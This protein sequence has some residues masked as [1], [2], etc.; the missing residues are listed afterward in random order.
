MPR[1]WVVVCLGMGLVGCGGAPEPAER[2]ATSPEGSGRV[3]G[4]DELGVDRWYTTPAAPAPRTLVVFWEVWCPHCVREMPKVGE[5]RDRVEGL[6]VVGLTRQSRGTSD[7][8]VAA[9][10]DEHGLDF[11]VG[12]TDGVLFEELGMRGIPA[13]VLLE[14]DRVVWEGH[15][16]RLT[17]DVFDR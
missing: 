17:D 2:G 7:A 6:Q 3:V 14:G 11:P 13:A 5:W 10:V 12:H 4:L 8:Q 1:S 16:A 9:F 15:P